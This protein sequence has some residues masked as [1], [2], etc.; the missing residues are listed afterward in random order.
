MRKIKP[1]VLSILEQ[2]NFESTLEQIHD[3]PPQ[4]TIN[5]LFSFLCSTDK[6]IKNNAVI[7]MGEVVSRMAETDLE[8]A[9][10]VMRRLIWSLNEE[11]G[12]IGWG[13]AESMGEIMARNETLA[14]EYHNLLI[15]F[16]TTGNN[17]LLYDKL[18][19]EVVQGLKRLSK[20]HPYLVQEVQHL[21]KEDAVI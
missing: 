5:A 16:V 21:L 19:E 7:A 11:S 14:Q 18:R 6:S 2:S 17:Y 20:V 13:S 10:T 8:S 9:R 15:S 4:K 1:F 3:L 12:W